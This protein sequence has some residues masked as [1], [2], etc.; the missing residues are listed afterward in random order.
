MYISGVCLVNF[1]ESRGIMMEWGD[2]PKNGSNF[3]GERDAS[4]IT[5]HNNIK[6]VDLQ[7]PDTNPDYILYK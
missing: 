1:N 7:H 4:K 6:A 5:D 2:F 3:R